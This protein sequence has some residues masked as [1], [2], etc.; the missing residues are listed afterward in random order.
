MR[1]SLEDEEKRE[2][3]KYRIFL[4]ERLLAMTLPMMPGIIPITPMGARVSL[5]SISLLVARV[6]PWKPRFHR[7]K[8]AGPGEAVGFL[9]GKNALQIRPSSS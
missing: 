3:R 2:A 1:K 5:H 9:P 7:I 4:V 8:V 6:V